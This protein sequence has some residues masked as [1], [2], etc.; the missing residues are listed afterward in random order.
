MTMMMIIL[1][2]HQ[3]HI[4]LVVATDLGHQ[5][6]IVTIED[7]VI[8]GVEV[9]GMSMMIWMIHTMTKIAVVQLEE[10]AQVDVA[11]QAEEVE[12]VGLDQER[13]LHTDK[14]MILMNLIYKK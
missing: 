13:H 6:V 8:A 11:D 9:E 4:V 3:R 5:D 12:V 2:A 10:V 7:M 1:E 14:S